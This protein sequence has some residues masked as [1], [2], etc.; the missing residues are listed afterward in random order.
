MGARRVQGDF[1]LTQG[2]I[3]A[4]GQSVEF[5]DMVS[6]TGATVQRAQDLLG[7]SATPGAW[8][9]AEATPTAPTMTDAG[10]AV[11]SALTN[12]AVHAKIS[13]NY[14]WGEGPLSVAASVTPSAGDA[15]IVTGLAPVS[16]GLST[17]LYVETSAGSG[18]YK[19]HSSTIGDNVFLTNYG[20]GRTPP[21]AVSVTATTVAQYN[22]AQAFLGVSNQRMPTSGPPAIYG[23]P[24]RPFGNSTDNTIMVCRGGVFE[25]DC[26]SASFAAGA[27]VGAAKATGNALLNQTV[28]AVSSPA[29]AIGKV[30]TD[31]TYSVKVMVEIQSIYKTPAPTPANIW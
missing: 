25:F 28:V 27:Y 24:K 26:V 2:Y 3:V 9:S 14:P 16:P 21:A 10:T 19:L 20:N 31:V 13:Y 4:T 15:V 29:L 5:M 12:A 30:F 23:T 6:Y 22:F 11:G 7:S 17:N 1:M 8:P 18:I